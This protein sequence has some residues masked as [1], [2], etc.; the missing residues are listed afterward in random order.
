MEKKVAVQENPAEAVQEN[1]AEAV[2]NAEGAEENW[3]RIVVVE[4]VR[5]N[6]QGILVEAVKK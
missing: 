6:D 5:K 2:Q 4:E 1:L 3:D